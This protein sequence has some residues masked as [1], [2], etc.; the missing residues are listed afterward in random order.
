MAIS[1]AIARGIPVVATAAGAVSEWLDPSAAILV[2]PG[3]VTEL[4]DALSRALSNPALRAQLRRGALDACRHLPRWQETAAK[5]DHA[6]L[7]RVA[8]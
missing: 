4:R 2:E 8:R 6:L 7:H 5:V 1:E 3:N